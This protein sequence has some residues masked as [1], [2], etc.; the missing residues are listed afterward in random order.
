MVNEAE[1]FKGRK[2]RKRLE[3][4]EQQISKITEEFDNKYENTREMKF[5]KDDIKWLKTSY[6]VFLMG[7]KLVYFKWKGLRDYGFI[8]LCAQWL[9]DRGIDEPSPELVVDMLRDVLP[10]DLCEKLGAQLK[11]V[12]FIWEGRR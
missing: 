1:L 5:L 11:S 9:S 3:A 12:E 7:Q 4:I 10:D 6:L 8:R 2:G